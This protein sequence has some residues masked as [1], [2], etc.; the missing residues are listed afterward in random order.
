MS[1]TVDGD[2]D[3]DDDGADDDGDDTFSAQFWQRPSPFGMI[4]P[5]ELIQP[6]RLFEPT[7]RIRPVN[8]EPVWYSRAAEMG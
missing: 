2:D 1:D 7:G 8:I 4:Q 6:E 3:D 5:R